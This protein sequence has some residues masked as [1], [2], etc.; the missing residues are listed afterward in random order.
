MKK[1][2]LIKILIV[3]LIVALG[4]FG[5]KF[6]KDKTTGNGTT[7]DKKITVTVIDKSNDTVL[8]DSEEFKTN[9]K[10]LGEFLSENSKTLETK[11]DKGQ[12]GTFILGIKGIETKDMKKGPWWMYSYKSPKGNLN[13]KRGEAPG[14]DSINL[15]TGDSVTFE[16]TNEM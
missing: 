3:V 13:Y 4:V 5:Y 9:A 12:F 8:V 1:S 16:F 2:L 10:T 11:L 15:Q 7:G 6:I 14:V